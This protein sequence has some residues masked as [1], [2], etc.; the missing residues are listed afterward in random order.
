M[1][2]PKKILSLQPK[3]VLDIRFWP[4]DICPFNK[5]SCQPDTHITKWKP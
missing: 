5:C 1:I 4:T 2:Q 3:E